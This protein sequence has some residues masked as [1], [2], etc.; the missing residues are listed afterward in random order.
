VNENKK[1]IITPIA[2]VLTVILLIVLAI[3][4]VSEIKAEAAVIPGE[5]IPG[6]KLKHY[7]MIDGDKP[8][9]GFSKIRKEV[10][11]KGAKLPEQT[12]IE[13]L[14]EVMYWENWNTDPEHEA[15]RLTGA[16]V[17]NRVKSEDWPDTIEKV[18]YQK[19]QYSTTGK[20]YSK[21]IPDECYEM[22]AN[23]IKY[24]TDDV[25]ETVVY[26]SMRIQG[27]GVWRKVET[28]YFCYK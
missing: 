28:D 8:L 12:D 4:M 6:V 9:A 14:A 16:V 25:P 2:S 27:S 11:D 7:V 21:T 26:Q 5:L 19:G 18:L 13:L 1:T 22:A 24:G 17:L 3:M 10:V 23:L 20:F 15:A